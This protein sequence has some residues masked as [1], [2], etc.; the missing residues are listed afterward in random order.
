MS[1]INSVLIA[2]RG[3]IAI[4]IS[5]TLNEMGIESYGI[6]SK[7]DSSSTHLSYCSKVFELKGIGPSAYLN[8]DEIISIAK[9]NN[10][11]AIHPGYGF[12]SENQTF[13]AACLKS[14]IVFIGPSEKTLSTFGDKEKAKKLAQKLD[15]P[16]CL[17]VGPVENETD[18]LSFFKKI[19][20]NKIILKA[21]F[22]GG[23]RGSRIVHKR[24]DISEVLSLVKQE[25]KSF[26][27]S[28]LVFAEE[29]IEDARHIEVQILGDGQS[30]IHFFERDC[31][32]QRNF[33][34]F[35]EFS[36]APNLKI[37]TKEMLYNY[38]VTLCK[39]VGYKGL[40]TVEFLVDKNEKIYFMEVNPRV[41]VEHTI[42]EELTG[43][44]LV[45]SQINVFCGLSIQDQ[46]LTEVNIIGNRA[47]IQ[48][49]LNMESYDDK[50]QLVPTT[51]TIKEYD[52]ASGP[53]IR[54]DGAG[55]VGF[56]NSGLYDSLLAKVIATSDFGLREAVRK[57]KFTLR[58][59]NI[60]GIET[61]KNLII[62][63]L[64][65]ENIENGSVNISSI[66]MKIESYLQK[67]RT[68]SQQIAIEDKTSEVSHDPQN[69]SPLSENVI[70]SE[71]VGTVISVNAAP[72]K[73]I[74]QG[75]TVL[76]QEAMK[77]HHPIKAHINGFISKF[78]VEVGDT[79]SIGTPLFEFI[80]DVEKNQKRLKTDTSK[81]SKTIRKDLVDLLERRKLTLDKNRSTAVKKRKKLGKRTA[82]ENIKS[83]IGKN[84]FF[85][86][87]DLAYA[88]QRSRR[89]LDDLIK[90]TP[91][92]GLITGVSFVNSDL[93]NKEK[94]K[95]AIMH[96]DYMVLAGTQGINNHKKLDRM[97]DVIRGLKAPLIFFCE[98]G[99]G[100]PGD[101][102][103][104]D[105]NIAGLNI[106]S[107]HNF[108][109]LSG[110]VPL[111]GIGSG[112]LFAGN[113]ALLGC[114][115]VIIGTR[116]LNLG[117]GGPAMIEGGGLG[118]YKPEEVG[119][120][121]VQYPNGVIDIL[122]DNEDDAVEMAKKYLSYFQGDLATWKAPAAENLR[123]VIPENRLEVYDIREVIDNIADI[124]SVL[125]IKAG[126]AKGMFTGFI[127]VKGK[128]WG[129]IANNP[130]YLA[131]AIDSN[132]ADKASRFIKLCENYNIPILSLCDTP[133]MMVGPEVEE[134][135]LVRHCCRM[136][137]AGANVTVPMV[138]IVLRKAYG[139]GAQAMAGGSFM[140]PQFVVGWPTA[141]I[142]AMGLEGAV[143]LGYRKEL[144]AETDEEKKEKLFKKLVD[145]LYEKGK[146]INAASL[147]EFDTV[148]DPIESR[149]WISM[150][151]ESPEDNSMKASKNRYIDSW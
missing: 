127:R 49:R 62:E 31:S 21:N 40:G 113:A 146:A 16:T 54:V 27:G 102:D 34:K 89:S 78:F 76:V 24:E 50:I 4:R 56:K 57:L 88:A 80:P 85:E 147:L 14:H 84:E 17:S 126:F 129:L 118:V 8:I 10:I 19:K 63:V 22:G 105:Q 137:L 123:T 20:K 110:V 48:A 136:F 36:P 104:G 52:I 94:T 125:E 98:G 82:R 39:S 1:V 26:S 135:G 66:D 43:I 32:F 46:N 112:R 150:V 77:M 120:T 131:G 142:G 124:G 149:N 96:Y 79:V 130:L 60:S 100:R 28:N 103:A 128:P 90:N 83:L 15:L 44:D 61:N 117:M 55:K 65:Q 122:V 95:T 144:E 97:I 107:F 139:L 3:E 140:A 45:R 70:Q 99:G 13:A 59:S 23:G 64:N 115:D 29:V 37:Q 148:L 51:G 58:M 116:D 33:Q 73:K 101:V 53:G 35:I 68:N 74:K 67:L 9:N 7:D 138:T 81:K 38:A 132:G 151:I 93:F 134:T 11:G 72:N 111:V 42:T 92:D 91:A 133:G 69:D 30:C 121:S 106:P 25:A 2:N 145:E 141:E 109:R 47:S 86:Y 75:D 108:A 5:K 71:L 87:G 114:C 143:K 12:L 18:L 6:Y 119:P 41:Q